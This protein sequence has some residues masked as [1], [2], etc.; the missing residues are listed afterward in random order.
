MAVRIPIPSG[1][2]P[3]CVTGNTC[4]T[5]GNYYTVEL[6]QPRGWDAGGARYAP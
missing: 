3:E 2:V 1:A 4:S 5:T 6:R